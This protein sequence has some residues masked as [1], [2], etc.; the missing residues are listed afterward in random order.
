MDDPFTRCRLLLG[1]EAFGK[2]QAARVTVLGLGAVGYTV[3]EGLVRSGLGTL[4]IMEFDTVKISNI[5]RQLLALHS[6]LDQPK[7]ELAAARLRDINPN[8]NLEVMPSFL[9]QHTKAPIL[10]ESGIV[11]DAIDSF[12]P[13]AYFLLSAHRQGL[14]V[15]SCMGAARRFDPEQVTAGD[16]WEVVGDPLAAPLRRFLG[17][18]GIRG[19]IRVIY[20][21]ELPVKALGEAEADQFQRGRLRRPIGSLMHIT[22]AFAARMIAE[23][24]DQICERV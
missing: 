13:K 4:R 16:L 22:L 9:D 7:V 14:R 3:A 21:R 18:H 6:T 20:S 2:M 23:V 12:G 24:M 5:N 8:V 10:E 15:V 1:E 11:V 19:G 17:R